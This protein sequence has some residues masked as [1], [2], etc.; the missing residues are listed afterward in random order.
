MTDALTRAKHAFW[1]PEEQRLRAPIRILTQFAIFIFLLLIVS[2]LS[3]QFIAPIIESVGLGHAFSIGL[4]SIPYFLAVYVATRLID[5][6][7]LQDIG[8]QPTTEWAKQYALGFLTGGLLITGAII[9]M[10]AFDWAEITGVIHNQSS[11]HIAILLPLFFIAVSATFLFQIANAAYLVKN[12]AEGLAGYITPAQAVGIAIG[13]RL[14]VGIFLF[15]GNPGATMYAL[16]TE[17]LL[18]LIILIAYVYTGKVAF[19]AGFAT[20]WTALILYLYGGHA[21]GFN[22]PASILNITFIGPAAITGGAFGVGGGLI[23]LFAV[24]IGI[25]ILFGWLRLTGKLSI[26][27][28]LYTRTET[29][30]SVFSRFR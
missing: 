29:L 12:A 14:I 9:F 20:G 16:F 27:K 13:I 26:P 10:L 7:P 15:S 2:V 25:F 17:T 3:Q 23:A 11:I 22:A 4:A 5:K 24:V 28:T 18:Q 8:L 21:A 19:P 30:P 1:N 6:R